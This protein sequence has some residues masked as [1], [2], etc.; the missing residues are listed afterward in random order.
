MKKDNEIQKVI[1]YCWFGGNPLPS[2]AV[3]CIESWK[4]Y[5]PDYEI[6]EWNES[7]FDVNII[8]YVAQAYAAKKYAF[9][10]D[11]A[12][13]WILHE[14]GGI[15]FDTDVEVVK[16]FKDILAEGPFMGL[17]SCEDGSDAPNPGLGFACIPGMEVYKELLKTYEDDDFLSKEGKQN[18]STIVV[19]TDNLLKSY[20]FDGTNRMQKIAGINVYPTDYFCPK[21][22]ATG[23]L[24]VT[25]NT[26]SI[27]WYDASWQPKS[28]RLFY[29][30]TKYFPAPLRSFL[31][32]TLK[33]IK[34]RKA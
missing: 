19:R 24:V 3:K 20:G 9:V 29:S 21:D 14:F 34:D 6:K 30:I 25:K 2:L 5:F 26:R 10:S 16:S 15:Y 8:P 13:L 18:L 1:H 11:Y 27:H 17:E 32:K 28:S 33:N 31:K 22:F 12:R 4:K 7:N 23:R